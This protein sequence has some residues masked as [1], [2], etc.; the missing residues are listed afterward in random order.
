[1][2][3]GKRT[4]TI[5]GCG[6]GS[7]MYVTPAA[8]AAVSEADVIVGA[9]RLLDLFPASR[10]ERIVVSG[11]INEALDRIEA[12]QDSGAI[13]VLVSGD[14]GLFSLAR[15]VTKRF[16]RAHCRIVPGVSSAQVA[17]A[18]LG[19]TWTDAKI[20]SAHK[21]DPEPDP[22]LHNTDKI[23]VLAGRKESLDWIA[24]QLPVDSWEDRRIF[25]M[26]DLTLESQ[27]IREIQH[28][29]LATLNVSPRTIVLIV[30]KSLLE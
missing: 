2:A 24:N 18:Q 6:P 10:A 23:A 29:R 19:L 20:I 4:I 30:R 12:R 3:I 5:V 11:K 7:P 16:G 13:A 17:F 14:P 8:E 21:Q 15:L 27:R 28:D 22:S 25:V 9:Q 1:M 26:E